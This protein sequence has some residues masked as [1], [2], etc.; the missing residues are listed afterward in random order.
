[1]KNLFLGAVLT[2]L[3]VGVSGTAIVHTPPPV[4]APGIVHTPP[5]VK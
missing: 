5:P 4:G 2:I 3:F 1:M